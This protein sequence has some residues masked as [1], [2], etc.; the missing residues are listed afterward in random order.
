MAC[1]AKDLKALAPDFIL[2]TGD[3]VSKQTREAMFEAR[4]L[5]DSLGIPYYPM[6]GNHDFVL[7]DSAVR[8]PGKVR[9]PSA[10]S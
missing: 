8:A 7:Q 10:R 4:D 5:M 1:L 2:A 9:P 3:I 6:G